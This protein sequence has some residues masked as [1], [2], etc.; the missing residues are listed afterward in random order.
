MK[1][2]N[3]A[4]Q[5][6]QSWAAARMFMMVAS[7]LMVTL[8]SASATQADDTSI[9][10]AGRVFV[11]P[12]IRHLKFSVNPIANLKSVQFLPFSRNPV[13]L[14]VRFRRLTRASICP[15]EDTW[16][17]AGNLR[18]PVFGLYDGFTNTV[19]LTYV[20]RDNSSKESLFSLA[21]P[22]FPDPCGYKQGNIVQAR[23][24]STS[25]S[26][27]FMLL[28]D[29]CSDLFFSC[30]DGYRRSTSLGRHRGSFKCRKCFF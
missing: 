1:I 26:Y 23:T 2:L 25:L 24:R 10:P 15:A 3:G 19:T 12:F 28:K 14:P 5:S 11:N 18:I 21:T 9:V 27:D 6:G 13:P 7:M 20:F 30:L 29:S 4:N 8:Q 17:A 22:A 16:S